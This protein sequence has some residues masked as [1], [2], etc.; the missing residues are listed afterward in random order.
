MT[1]EQF[2]T[3][4]N[5]IGTL[6]ENSLHAALKAL[7]TQPGDLVEEKVDGFVIDIVRDGLLIEIQTRHFSAIKNK[8]NRL[9]ENHK[10]QLVYPI[11]RVKWIVRHNI[12]GNKLSQR[13]SPARGR[14]ENVFTELVRIPALITHPNFCLEAVLVEV[15]EIRVDDGRGSWR[16]KGW[17]IADTKL[18]AIDGVQ[19]FCSTDDFTALLP[20]DLPDEFSVKDAAKQMKIPRYLAGKM[21]YCLRQMNAV[22][23]CGH[24]GRAYLYRYISIKPGT[25]PGNPGA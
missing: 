20:G 2:Q 5:G 3:A 23:H 15:E 10:V 25:E 8:L 21:L 4:K 19:T 12:D 17:S 22:E 14:I 18:I 13:R 24:K 7:Y 6:K 11:A 9:L 1:E 16:R